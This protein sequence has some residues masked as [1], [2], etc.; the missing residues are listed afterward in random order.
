MR[1]G[2]QEISS[3]EPGRGQARNWIALLRNRTN[4]LDQGEPAMQAMHIRFWSFHEKK[5]KR[6]K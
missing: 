2:L 6:V 5:L 1:K 3:N 4:D